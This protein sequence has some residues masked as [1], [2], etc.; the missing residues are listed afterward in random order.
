MSSFFIRFLL[1]PH[2]RGSRK[3]RF[4]GRLFRAKDSALPCLQQDG[5]AMKHARHF[6]ASSF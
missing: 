6:S 2:Q 1:T 4:F 5:C 3:N